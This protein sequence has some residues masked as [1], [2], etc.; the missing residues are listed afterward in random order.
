MP[1][2]SCPA[3]SWEA[4]SH[5]TPKAKSVLIQKTNRNLVIFYC[6]LFCWW[7]LGVATCAGG[8]RQEGSDEQ[9]EDVNFSWEVDRGNLTLY[10]DWAVPVASVGTS[11]DPAEV[12]QVKHKYAQRPRVIAHRNFASI[13]PMHLVV[14]FFSCLCAGKCVGA[15]RFIGIAII[16]KF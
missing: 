11:S 8:K 5:D 7:S 13:S 9:L 16:I 4:E 1:P 14:Q 6:K 10:A 15:H 3:P 2:L 12:T